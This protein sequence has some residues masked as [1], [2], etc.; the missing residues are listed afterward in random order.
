MKC[1]VRSTPCRESL[2]KSIWAPGS[3]TTRTLTSSVDKT[4]IPV[5]DTRRF[6]D[7][8]KWGDLRSHLERADVLAAP[9]QCILAAVH[10][11]V[12]AFLVPAQA[13]RRCGNSPAFRPHLAPQGSRRP[14]SSASMAA[15]GAPWPRRHLRRAPSG[16]CRRPDAPRTGRGFAAVAGNQILAGCPWQDPL[17][18]STR[19]PSPPSGCGIASGE[20]RQR[21]AAATSVAR[22]ACARCQTGRRGLESR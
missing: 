22:V 11:E 21:L 13:C 10:E 15:L 1:G 6:L 17:P 4:W 19:G 20:T 5:G 9:A 3:P 7:S 8:T 18:P 14:L 2:S 16:P 12:V